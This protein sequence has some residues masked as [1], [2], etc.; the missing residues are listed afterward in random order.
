MKTSPIKRTIIV[1]L[2]FLVF[3]LVISCSAPMRSE[4]GIGGTG[5]MQQCSDDQKD[6]ETG[7]CI[8]KQ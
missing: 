7:E 3:N 4:G 2:L 5:T 8:D 1:G 6:K